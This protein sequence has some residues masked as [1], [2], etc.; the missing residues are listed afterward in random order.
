M[1]EQIERIMSME[2]RLD[3][4]MKELQDLHIAMEQMNEVKEDVNALSDYYE[5]GIWRQDYESDEAGMLP[6]DLK[7][8]VL[9][10]DAIYDILTEYDAL[11]KQLKTDN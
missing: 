5:N 3:R 6:K 8:G 11:G 1:K 2:E 9:S 10:Q 7:R 4:V